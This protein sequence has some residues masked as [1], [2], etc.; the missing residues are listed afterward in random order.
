M[1]RSVVTSGRREYG[2]SAIRGMEKAKQKKHL[3]IN[4]VHLP[5]LLVVRYTVCTRKTDFLRSPV[6]Y[7]FFWS[8][9]TQVQIGRSVP[10]QPALNLVLTHRIRMALFVAEGPPVPIIP[11]VVLKVARV[12]AVAYSSCYHVPIDVRG[13]SSTFPSVLNVAGVTVP[14]Y[15]Y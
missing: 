1:G 9:E 14:A 8:G 3:C 10:R 5:I 15:F 11:L 6:V 4:H 2:P 13:S 12:T 7:L